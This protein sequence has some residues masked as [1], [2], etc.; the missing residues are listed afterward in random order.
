MALELEVFGDVFYS[1]PG[2]VGSRNLAGVKSGQTTTRVFYE[3][4]LTVGQTPA[5]VFYVREKN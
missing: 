5:G 3:I 2:V 4:L 1:R